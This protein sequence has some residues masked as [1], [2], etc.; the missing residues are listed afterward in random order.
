MTQR[1]FTLLEVVVAIA[2]FSL[3]GLATYQFLDR[4]MRSD[5]RIGQHEQQLRAL[6]RAISVLERDL[7]QARRQ[8]LLDDPSHSQALI[9]QPDG[10]SLVRGGWSN[11]LEYPRSNLLQASHR[12]QDGVWLRETR[13]L[14]QP[15]AATDEA[16]RAPGPTGQQQQLLTGVQLT[17]LRFIDGLGQAHEHWP[18]GTESLSLPAAL[19]IELDAPG[20]PQ[21]RRVILLPGGLDS[22][23]E[24]GND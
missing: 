13:A 14:S 1:G 8:P 5:Q 22:D 12:W 23:A 20:Y 18:V 3:L 16:Q 24:P 6:Q 19:E 9:S 17:R 15:L 4:V 11:P 21:I 2:I 7:V 10:I